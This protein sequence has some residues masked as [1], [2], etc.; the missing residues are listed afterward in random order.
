[1]TYVRHRGWKKIIFL[2]EAGATGRRRRSQ[3]Y[4]P[5]DYK[6]LGCRNLEWESQQ[7]PREIHEIAVRLPKFLI[8]VKGV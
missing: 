8:Y 4:N 1:M 6:L 5:P 7:H 2:T 3:V